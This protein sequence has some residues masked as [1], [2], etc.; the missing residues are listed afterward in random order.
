LKQLAEELGVSLPF[1]G[2]VEV[3]Q[4]T[5]SPKT[6]IALARALGV[7]VAQIRPVRED[8]ALQA[9]LFPLDQYLELSGDPHDPA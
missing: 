5:A 7:T 2:L 6:L 9:S 8:D 1:I 3:G 4:R